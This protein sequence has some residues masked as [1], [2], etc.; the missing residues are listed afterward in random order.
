MIVLSEDTIGISSYV[1]RQTGLTNIFPSIRTSND[2]LV[3]F[4]K[5][6]KKIAN[7]L[8]FLQK[9]SIEWSWGNKNKKKNLRDI[10]SEAIVLECVWSAITALNS[11]YAT[12]FTQNCIQNLRGH[13]PPLGRI[14]FMAKSDGQASS[15]RFC[16]HTEYNCF[17]ERFLNC[18]LTKLEGPQ[19]F[20]SY[21]GFGQR[22]MYKKKKGELGSMFIELG[23][24][25]QNG[26]P[27]S[28]LKTFALVLTWP[29]ISRA[30]TWVNFL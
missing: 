3:A 24:Y 7:N 9:K 15:R 29:E 12:K 1:V 27:I 25:L 13:P 23:A 4:E 18:L 2:A 11:H 30:G 6:E 28:K 19:R 8:C 20:W 10:L 22:Q 26:R 5:K 17:V 21:L 14:D 16:V